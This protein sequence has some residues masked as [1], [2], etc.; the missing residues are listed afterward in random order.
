MVY[1]SKRET[2]VTIYPNFKTLKF[3]SAAILKHN[4]CN[5]QCKSKTILEYLEMMRE[6]D[7]GIV[8]CHS[9]Y[10][11][12]KQDKTVDVAVYGKRIV[13]LH[14]YMIV[15]HSAETLISG[16]G[17]GYCGSYTHKHTFISRIQV[18]WLP[19]SLYKYVYLIMQSVMF[20]QKFPIII[21]RYF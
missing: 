14:L 3:A 18:W 2:E 6:A 10:R 21:F 15:S 20:I 19:I 12:S 5:E 17:E 9:T 16:M 1:R 11:L 4:Q 13:C 8:R 7:A